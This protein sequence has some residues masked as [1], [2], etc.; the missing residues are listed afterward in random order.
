MIPRVQKKFR[1]KCRVVVCGNFIP[2]QGQNVYASGTSADT[3]RIAVALAVK[4]EWC[5]GSTDVANAFTL[6]PMPTELSYAL[7]PPAIVTL[8][9]AATPG[10]T[11]QIT[12][13]LYGLREAPRLWGDFRNSRFLDAEIK[14]GER[15]I[16]LKATTTDENL[17]RIMFQGED[18]VQGLVL[19]LC[20]RYPHVVGKRGGGVD[21]PMVGLRVEVLELGMGRGWVTEISGH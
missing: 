10:E 1:R 8:A 15:I 18:G 20:R 6:A 19:V 16:V 4:N 7:T 14:Y 9:G 5:I 17:W 13:V 21:L 2:A 11:W 3:L 12:R